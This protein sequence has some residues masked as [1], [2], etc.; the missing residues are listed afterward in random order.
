MAKEQDGILGRAAESESTGTFS[1]SLGKSLSSGVYVGRDS[2]NP[3]IPAGLSRPVVL[4]IPTQPC[5]PST[6]A[7]SNSGT[8]DGTNSQK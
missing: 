3:D 8:S 5:Q 2:Q 7:A 1:E 4:T 6:A